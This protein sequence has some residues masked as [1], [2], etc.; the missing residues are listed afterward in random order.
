MLSI[1]M[2]NKEYISIQR[3]IFKKYHADNLILN[4]II[5]FNKMCAEISYHKEDDLN[6]STI[7]KITEI[8]EKYT[9]KVWVDTVMISKKLIKELTVNKKEVK[10]ISAK[11]DSILERQ[12]IA[13]D[14]VIKYF[15]TIEEDK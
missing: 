13:S 11:I 14:L 4:K 7:K 5:E 6:E 9:K 12:N 8:V 10:T 3:K 15:K 1:L 2:N